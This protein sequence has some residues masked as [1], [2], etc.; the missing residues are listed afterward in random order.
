MLS[1]QLPAALLKKVDTYRKIR[2]EGTGKVIM[3]STAIAELLTKALDGIDPARP[4]CGRIEELESRVG[5]LE[6][7]HKVRYANPPTPHTTR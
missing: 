5:A 3:R 2:R 6:A 4:L 7:I 1:K